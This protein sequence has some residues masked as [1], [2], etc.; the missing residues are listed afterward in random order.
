MEHKIRTVSYIKK[1]A[2]N[3]LPI[4]DLFCMTNFWHCWGTKKYCISCRKLDFDLFCIICT[5]FC[6]L[7]IQASDLHYQIKYRQLVQV[8]KECVLQHRALI[9][10]MWGTTN[11]IYKCSSFNLGR[12]YLVNKFK[13]AKL[14]IFRDFLLWTLSLVDQPWIRFIYMSM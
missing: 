4:T 13:Q 14:F 8:Q 9:S 2:C 6:L 5:F 1:S 11:L 10:T 7:E 12:C 3:L